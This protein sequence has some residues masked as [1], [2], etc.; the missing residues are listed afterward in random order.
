M[1][2][3][4]GARLSSEAGSQSVSS[5]R[6]I[7][8]LQSP[9]I[10]G[11]TVH[12]GGTE[13]IDGWRRP[14]GLDDTGLSAARQRQERQLACR[15]LLQVLV[16]VSGSRL[17][18]SVGLPRDMLPGLCGLCSCEGHNTSTGSGTFPTPVALQFQLNRSS[19]QLLLQFT[20]ISSALSLQKGRLPS[21]DFPC[22]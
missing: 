5:P 10:I 1:P 2:A 19:V 8:A 12:G 7:P 15:R 11:S 3:T 6:H 16:S 13:E 4:S 17:D 14:S 22:G 21:T 20:Y 18:S 9:C